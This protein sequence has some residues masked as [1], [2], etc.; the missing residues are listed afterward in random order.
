M[1]SIIELFDKDDVLC[2]E[3]LSYLRLEDD[4]LD[5]T[6][7]FEEGI[8]T[9]NLETPIKTVRITYDGVEYNFY[10]IED[11]ELVCLETI[12]EDHVIQY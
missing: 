6:Y 9:W 10:A 4:W 8:H 2:P 5:S 7:S 1:I 12:D 3:W 11:G